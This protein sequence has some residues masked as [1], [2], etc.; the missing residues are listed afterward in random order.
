MN[1]GWNVW[2]WHF[3]VVMCVDSLFMM[4]PFVSI[5]VLYHALLSL[6]FE[7]H[8]FF[9]YMRI[10]VIFLSCVIFM[11]SFLSMVLSFVV[12]HFDFLFLWSYLISWRGFCFWLGFSIVFR[13]VRNNQEM[14]IYCVILLYLY[15]SYYNSF[16][17]TLLF[18]SLILLSLST[19]LAFYKPCLF[20]TLNDLFAMRHLGKKNCRM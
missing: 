11:C 20:L 8:E 13:L 1:F 4:F 5:V 6:F 15:F 7:S 12:N 19:R 17:D 3:D 16:I 18:L 10:N 14:W 9:H 2:F